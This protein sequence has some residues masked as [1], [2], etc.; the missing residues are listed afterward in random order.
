LRRT[1]SSQVAADLTSETFARALASLDRYEDRGHGFG[2]WLQGIAQNELRHYLRWRRVDAAARRRLGIARLEV[3]ESAFDAVERGIDVQLA[4]ARAVQ[5]M[6]Q[7]SPRLSAAIYLRFVLALPYSEIAARL[8]CSESA[9]RVRVSRG[10][11]R[12]LQSMEG[13][14]HE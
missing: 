8:G 6:T 11:T 2:S 4:Y 12:L 5:H 9:A 10:L 7:L 1:D 3:D 14:Q 13:V